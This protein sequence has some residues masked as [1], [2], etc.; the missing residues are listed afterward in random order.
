MNR[1]R[2][3]LVFFMAFC[4]F[5]CLGGVFLLARQRLQLD[6]LEIVLLGAIGSIKYLFEFARTTRLVV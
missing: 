4:M 2:A 6:A 5:L 3:A 1:W